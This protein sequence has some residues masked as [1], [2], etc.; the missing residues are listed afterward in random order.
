MQKKSN[1][2]LPSCPRDPSRRLHPEQSPELLGEVKF[3][4]SD[5]RNPE[6]QSDSR[7]DSEGTSRH[8]QQFPRLPNDW[9]DTAAQAAAAGNAAVAAVPG[10]RSVF[11]KEFQLDNYGL[12]KR[13]DSAGP[14]EW[15]SQ[16]LDWLT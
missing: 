4:Q 7:S 16:P 2:R 9:E 11:L 3:R 6:N 8:Q 14:K 15:T 5:F 1:P 12:S 10:L 13:P